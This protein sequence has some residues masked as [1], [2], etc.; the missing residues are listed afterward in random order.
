MHEMRL[1]FAEP[2]NYVTQS[3]KAV[4]KIDDIQL[5]QHFYAF[6]WFLRNTR[7]NQSIQIIGTR[8]Q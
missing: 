2:F 6:L 8:T 3:E 1:T 4:L 5:S 7:H